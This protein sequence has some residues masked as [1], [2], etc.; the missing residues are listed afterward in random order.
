VLAHLDE[1]AKT[2]EEREYVLDTIAEDMADGGI[3]LHDWA[4]RLTLAP[5]WAGIKTS[6][7]ANHDRADTAALTYT[8]KLSTD[9]S[10][11]LS[12]RGGGGSWTDPIEE[13]IF[14]APERVYDVTRLPYHG[15]V[16][17]STRDELFIV[18]EAE[19]SSQIESDLRHAA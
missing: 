12:L 10:G 13:R 5:E 11:A 6:A 17:L 16:A 7:G 14:N 1:I 2:Q 15:L 8:P 18:T 9:A 4:N 19:Y 3:T